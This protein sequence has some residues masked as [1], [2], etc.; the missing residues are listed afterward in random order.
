MSRVLDFFADL[1]VLV[2]LTDVAILCGL[3]ALV[4]AGLALPRMMGIRKRRDF[5]TRDDEYQRL[6]K[7]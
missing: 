1:A 6:Q 3:A 2:T 5:Q 4:G 7:M